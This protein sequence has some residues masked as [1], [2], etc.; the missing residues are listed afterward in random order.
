MLNSKKTSGTSLARIGVIA[1][2]YIVT[3]MS[4]P[5]LSYGSIQ[6]RISEALT[7]LP[8]FFPEAVV[9][10]FIGCLISNILGNGILDIVFGSLATLIA[11]VLTYIVGKTVKNTTLKFLLGAFPPVIINAIVVPFTYLV[12]TELE[13]L[14]WFNFLTVFIGQFLAVY[15]LG[16]LL[17]SLIKKYFK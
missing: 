6:L 2:L 8:L 15:V 4:L 9:G 10:L 7:V 3:T 17:Y 13:A 5:F 11:G 1:G 16:A 12:V 14:Y